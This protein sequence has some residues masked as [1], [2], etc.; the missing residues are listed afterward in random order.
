MIQNIAAAVLISGALVLGVGLWGR[1]WVRS[2]TLNHLQPATRLGLM[3][4][5]GVLIFGGYWYSFGGV[6]GKPAAPKVWT[7]SGVTLAPAQPLVTP[8]AAEPLP[9]SGQP[10]ETELAAQAEQA[11]QTQAASPATVLSEEVPADP[12]VETPAPATE[13]GPVPS[14]AAQAPAPRIE[15]APQNTA[16]QA[17][18]VATEP[19]TVARAEP[20]EASPP[21]R[22]KPASRERSAGAAKA[23]ADGSVDVCAVQVQY[24]LIP[25]K[26]ERRAVTDRS[27]RISIR[28]ALGPGQVREKL[29]LLIEGRK[30][31]SFEISRKKPSVNVS[32][33]LPQGASAS[34]YSLT[35]TTEY[36]DG[37]RRKVSGG[38]WLEDGVRR[39]ELRTTGGWDA[40]GGELFLEPAS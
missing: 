35:G 21:I 34:S 27:T 6:F 32:L 14:A 25:A 40:R 28:N 11:E 18:A 31:A 30:V 13:S 22:S 3:L 36:E 15:P 12:A 5:G 7:T 38:G 29:Q 4:L 17:A 33:S 26:Q 37:E 16:T 1:F 24:G 23:S 8:E 20:V 19:A 2:G 9:N 39:Y 10:P